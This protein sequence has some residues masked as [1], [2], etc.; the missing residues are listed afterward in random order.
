MPHV[1][2]LKC[3]DGSFY[4]GSTRDLERRMLEHMSGEGAAYTRSR[5]PVE[6]VFAEE[7]ERVDEAYTREKQLQGWSRAKRQALIDRSY[8]ALPG[9][10]RSL[11]RRRGPV[12]FDTRP[13]DATQSTDR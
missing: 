1:Y 5:Q 2:M 11:Y 8:G 10:S 6:L 13:A 4:V 7:Y 9:L 12:D 3:S